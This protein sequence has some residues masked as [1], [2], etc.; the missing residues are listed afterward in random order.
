MIGAWNLACLARA[1]WPLFKTPSDE[2]RKNLQDALDTYQPRFELQWLKRMRAKLGIV[3]AGEDAGDRQII[4]LWMSYLEHES[5][6]F[7]VSFRNLSEVV[8]NA[9]QVN[10]IFPQTDALNRFYQQWWQRVSQQSIPLEKIALQM[11]ET[12]PLFIPRNH[13]VERAI[14]HAYHGDFKVFH[15]LCKVLKQPYR[16]QPSF[17]SYAVPPH[18]DERVQNTFC[19]T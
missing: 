7:T 6:D 5:L 2:T 14:N 12:N 17:N 8:N 10:P 9:G 11:D 19:G 1:L 16:E 3:E 18:K 13:Q 4:T 15:E